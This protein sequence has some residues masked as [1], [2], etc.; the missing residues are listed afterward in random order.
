MLYA[1]KKN[2]S[3]DVEGSP[4]SERE[5]FDARREEREEEEVAI[6]TFLINIYCFTHFRRC[7]HVPSMT[8]ENFYVLSLLRSLPLC[9]KLRLTRKFINDCILR[10]SRV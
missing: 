10:S 5:R 9:F 3:D 8:I 4:R 2:E 1:R 6:K 7:L